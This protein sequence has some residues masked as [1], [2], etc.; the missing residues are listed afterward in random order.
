MRK[1]Y[2]KKDDASDPLY[3]YSAL[4]ARDLHDDIHRNDYSFNY[5]DLNRKYG[6]DSDDDIPEMGDLD[7]SLDDGMVNVCDLIRELF[8]NVKLDVDVEY[9]ELDISIYVFLQKRE[10][11]RSIVRAFEVIH[12]LQK[13]VLTQYDSEVE[14]Y[15]NKEGFPILAFQFYSESIDDRSDDKGAPF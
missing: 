2:E 12:K 13:D 5:D 3:R 10:K 7:I 9:D 8:K 6:P 1:V 14:L 4:G 11:M 15:E